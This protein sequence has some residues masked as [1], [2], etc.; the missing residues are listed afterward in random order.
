MKTFFLRWRHEIAGELIE[1]GVGRLEGM[2]TG[3]IAGA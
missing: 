1:L 2:F 3:R